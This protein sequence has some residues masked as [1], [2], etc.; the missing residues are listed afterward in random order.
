M[1]RPISASIRLSALRA[2]LALARRSAP[3]ARVLAVVKANAYGH[4]LLRAARAFADADGFAVLELDDAVQLRAAGIDR[5]ILLLEGFFDV[6]ELPVI[7]AE[8]LT[9]VVHSDEQL[10][11]LQAVRLPTAVDVFVKIDT[12]MNRLGFRPSALPRVLE[13]LRACSSVG[14]LTLMT[15]FACADDVRGIDWQFDAFERA[16]AGLE[17]PL[18]LANSA[19]MLRYPRAA[20]GWARPGI[21]LYG[22]SPFAEESAQALGLRP[23][24]TLRSQLIATHDLAAGDSVGYGALF[25][26]RDAMRIG[27]VACGYA[28]G[29]PRHAPTGTPVLVAGA[30]TRLIG[31]VSMDMLCVDLTGLPQAQV[32]APVVLWGDDLPVEEVAHAAGTIS[33]ELLCA[34]AARVPVVEVD[35][36]LE[37]GI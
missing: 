16:S 12:G 19:T 35:L 25:Q 11:M 1:T 8:R 9:C 14:E 36:D 15:H 30:R 27:V 7:A 24:M 31:R 18:S 21:M 17:L 28:D 34:L 26:A 29:Y 22:S 5:R 20:A 13:A 10:A 4:G 37:V 32:G 2:N 33:Y 23:A 6:T 3:Q